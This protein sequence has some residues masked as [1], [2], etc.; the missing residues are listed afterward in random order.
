MIV[1]DSIGLEKLADSMPNKTLC[2]IFS[3]SNVTGEGIQLLKSFMS[4]LP[5]IDATSNL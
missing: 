3:L 1:K 2:P 4:K 5:N